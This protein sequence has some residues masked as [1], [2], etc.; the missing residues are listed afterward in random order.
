M[1]VEGKVWLTDVGHNSWWYVKC[2]QHV[3]YITLNSKIWDYSDDILS[4]GSWKDWRANPHGWRWTPPQNRPQPHPP[5]MHEPW[6]H[7][8]IKSQEIYIIVPRYKTPWLNIKCLC[9]QMTLHTCIQTNWWTIWFMCIYCI[10]KVLCYEKQKENTIF[11][12][13]KI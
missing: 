3:A 2:A 13:I 11:G 5:I 7:Q 1:A 8:C 6:Q 9:K 4:G 12:G 10:H